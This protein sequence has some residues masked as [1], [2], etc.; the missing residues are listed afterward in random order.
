MATLPDVMSRAKTFCFAIP[1]ALVL[2]CSFRTPEP[3]YISSTPAIETLP[4]LMERGTVLQ[5]AGDFGQALKVFEQAL[6]SSRET[7]ARSAE[8]EFLMKIA[9]LKWNIG[10]IEESK[11]LYQESYELANKNNNMRSRHFCVKVLELIEHYNSGKDQRQMARYNNSI[12]SFEAALRIEK[13]IDCPEFAVK[14]LRL[15]SAT[16]W[17]ME[18]F[19]Q[20]LIATNDALKIAKLI[21][22]RS[23]EGRCLNSLGLEY[24][25]NGDYIQALK[26]YED[27][28][29]IAKNL[30]DNYLEA[31]CLN[32]I[33]L[34]YHYCGDINRAITY[35]EKCLELDKVLGDNNSIVMDFSNIAASYIHQFVITDDNEYLKTSLEYLTRCK[36]YVSGLETKDELT[37]IANITD[38]LNKLGKY[39]ESIECLK[40]VESL[41]NTSFYKE[42]FSTLNLNY[43]DACYG[44]YDL[45]GAQEKYDIAIRYALESESEIAIW[46]AYYGLGKLTVIQ[47]KTSDSKRYFEKALQIIERTKEKIALDTFAAGYLCD[48]AEVYEKYIEL[49]YSEY[50]NTNS[51]SLKIEILSLIERSKA[52]SLLASLNQMS[53]PSKKSEKYKT[54]AE[55]EQVLAKELSRMSIALKNGHHSDEEEL[56]IAES[57]NELEDEYMRHISYLENERLPQTDL[58]RPLSITAYALRRNALDKGSAILE[59][60]IGAKIS[61]LI[62]I[63]QRGIEIYELPVKDE[64]ESMV[65][66]YV[67]VIGEVGYDY[68]IGPASERLATKILFP[69]SACN[70][71]NHLIIIPDN[72]LFYVPFETLRIVDGHLRSKYLIEKYSISYSPSSASLII[73]NGKDRINTGEVTIIGCNYRIIKSTNK[74]L[75]NIF[76]REGVKFSPIPSI[77]KEIKNIS[78]HFPAESLVVYANE[79]AVESNIKRI[80]A[81]PVDI[82]HFACHGILDEVNPFRSALVLTQDDNPGEDGFLQVREIYSMRIPAEL[83]VLSACQTGRGRLERG[84]GMMGLPRIFF[85]A[86]ARSVI[87]TLWKINDA[88]TAVF[89]DKFYG[90]LAGGE[91][92]AEALRSAK[93]E[94]IQS[95]YSHPAYWAAFILNGE[96]RSSIEVR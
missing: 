41:K 35:L 53:I 19:Q 18:E 2:F 63:T 58:F 14:C 3:Q 67:K 90:H 8:L 46:R 51:E 86:G 25:R 92:K 16:Y 37:I 20:F 28:Y 43:G 81:R 73:I 74:T 70:D 93:I 26:C 55:R 44:Q 17:Q 82:V 52:Q 72:V 30:K 39:K 89:M 32:N 24:M 48:K 62:M 88:S 68:G 23:E 56:F 76:S 83:V 12:S 38:V 9:L 85:H 29:D 6:V 50:R 49:V 27:A 34:I 4:A 40:Q 31:G 80:A 66:G 45:K 1:L 13:E 42:E 71:I 57:I 11:E 79:N 96:Y 54:W 75:A 87:S 94:M 36:E 60:Y 5:K 33:G 69:L 10:E 84:E 61:L 65:A 95:R 59:Y 7:R 15:L 47:G 22:H 91:S 78:K 77:V 21:N 64:L